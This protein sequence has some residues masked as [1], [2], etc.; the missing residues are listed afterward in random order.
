MA[1]GTVK[2]IRDHPVFGW[3]VASWQW[4][5]GK[6][7]A[8]E[9]FTHPEWTHNEY[10]NVISDYGLVGF[11][12]LAWFFVS[13]YRHAIRASKSNLP[14]EQRAFVAGSAVA[15]TSVLVH[16]WFDFPLHI[17]G[18]AV[19]LAVI[20]GCT[21]AIPRAQENAAPAGLKL[22]ARC[23]L[24]VVLF[25]VC[26][27]IAWFY[28]RTALAMH[29]TLTGNMSKVEQVGDKSEALEYYEQAIALDPD[30]P[31]PHARIGDAYR[32]LAI[33]RTR[34]D[35]LEERKALAVDAAEAYQRS[36]DL[37]P[38]DSDV[39]LRLGQSYEMAGDDDSALK[40]YLQA[41]DVDPANA[42]VHAML[43]RYYRSHGNLEE[44]Y[45]SFKRS[46]FLNSTT[47]S[48]A[49]FGLGEIAPL[50]VPDPAALNP[51]NFTPLIKPVSPPTNPPASI[52]TNK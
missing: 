27:S 20:A 37:N 45:N 24:A 25:A 3:G 2:L 7:K 17:P 5:Y 9:V 52:P 41:A 8:R 30:Y 40:N 33:W 35:K 10:L 39:L 12:L 1:T 29:Y 34:K 50:G 19:L 28:G 51:T 16:S 48:Q 43:G 46:Q 26:G 36:A 31:E 32:T 38:Y 13:F 18:N 14:S 22:P 6:Y 15:V 23:A 44:A 4:V 42:Y 47:D 11:L 21:A 49:N